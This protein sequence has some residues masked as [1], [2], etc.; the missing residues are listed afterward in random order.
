MSENLSNTVALE[1]ER[2]DLKP[3][4]EGTPTEVTVKRIEIGIPDAD[5]ESIWKPGIMDSN[6]GMTAAHDK[7]RP[8]IYLLEGQ[9]A[10]AFRQEGYESGSAN[11]PLTGGDQRAWFKGSK[12]RELADLH[13]NAA[14]RRAGVKGREI[15]QT[16]NGRE[17]NVT[18][19]NPFDDG[20]FLDM[21]NV[22][23]IDSSGTETINSDIVTRSANGELNQSL[24]SLIGKMNS[25]NNTLTW[26]TPEG[27]VQ[28]APYS[29][30]R[31]TRL[32]EFGYTHGDIN[33]PHSNGERF[34]DNDD[35]QIFAEITFADMK[36][37]GEKMTMN[38]RNQ[39]F[40]RV[41]IPTGYID[42]IQ[43]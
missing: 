34:K 9:D 21:T 37:K 25:N 1:L 36:R 16:I 40:G 12:S 11:V 28:I 33:V 20:D 3:R 8:V 39:K 27:K 43:H 35:E 5:K 32:K 18:T 17:Y 2:N 14:A 13:I 15:K 23:E 38:D 4:F 7:S 31:A 6:N 19:M 41:M 24:D 30:D 10:D 22:V 29:E 42:L 26:V